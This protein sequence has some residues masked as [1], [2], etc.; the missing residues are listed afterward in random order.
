MADP[1]IGQ[2]AA[3][4]WERKF[5][6]KPSDVIFNSRALFY[7]LQDGGFK[8]KAGGGRL[9]EYGVEYALIDWWGYGANSVW[10]LVD[11]DLPRVSFS[12]SY[13]GDDL[14]GVELVDPFEICA[15]CES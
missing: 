9:F 3:T 1:N 11:Q 10:L 5:G 15:D 12:V 8:E 6:K 4:V 13:N 7:L 14:E 2:V